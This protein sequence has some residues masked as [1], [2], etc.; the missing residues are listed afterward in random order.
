MSLQF[1]LERSKKLK[2]AKLYP[3]GDEGGGD[4]EPLPPPDGDNGG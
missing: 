4:D 3:G 2:K 1:L